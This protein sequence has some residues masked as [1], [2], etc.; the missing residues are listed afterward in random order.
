MGVDRCMC[1]SLKESLVSSQVLIH[2]DPSLPIRLA[3]DAS[4]YGIGAV[5]S[6]VLDDGTECPIAYVSKTLSPSEKNYAQIKKRL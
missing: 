1:C 3:A 2:Y 6:H 5:L 4:A